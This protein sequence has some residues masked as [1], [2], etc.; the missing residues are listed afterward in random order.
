MFDGKKN[1]E[2][3]KSQL[4]TDREKNSTFQREFPKVITRKTAVPYK[5]EI[6]LNKLTM[7]FLNYDKLKEFYNEEKYFPEKNMQESCSPR[8]KQRYNPDTDKDLNIFEYFNFQIKSAVF[9]FNVGG[10]GKE[11]KSNKQGVENLTSNKV[12]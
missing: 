4:T 8:I 3:Q 1:I 11:G 7:G 5:S 9:K 10:T 6:Q 2:L 12:L